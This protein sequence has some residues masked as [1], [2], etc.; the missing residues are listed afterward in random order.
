MIATLL[1][2]RLG[3]RRTQREDNIEAYDMKRLLIKSSLAF[4]LLLVIAL[5]AC[6]GGAPKTSGGSPAT[7]SPA[8]A[9][10]SADV[11]KIT[12]PQVAVDAGSSLDA[13][14]KVSIKAGFHIN[15]N[16]PTFS[17]LI[18]TEV[19]AGKAEGITPGKPVYPAGEKRKFQFADQPLSVYAGD[20]RV[21]LPLRVD[22]S[23]AKGARTLPITV[24]VQACDD[25][26]CYPPTTLNAT[27]QVEVK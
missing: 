16:P 17:Y 4:G 6:S 21:T 5:E 15:A 9:S 20:A 7:S 13:V 12:S 8:P 27:I 2:K 23:T 19:T 18:P 24:R 3:R 26:Q 11:V 10:S 14:V 25:Q 22:G 1:I